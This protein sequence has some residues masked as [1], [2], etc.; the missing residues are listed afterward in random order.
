M[1]D[2]H[3]AVG[4]ARDNTGMSDLNPSPPS[5]LSPPS[6]PS[7]PSPLSPSRKAALDASATLILLVCCTLWG[8]N[9]IA[10][11]VSLVDVPPLM[12]AA[13]RSTGAVVLVLA[14]AWWRRVQGDRSVGPDDFFASKADA[15]RIDRS[16]AN[17]DEAR[18]RLGGRRF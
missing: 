13:W 3:G 8:L 11:K 12:Q 17:V 9:Q 1:R 18:A 14:W 6:P 16:R 2:G 7:P 15:V 5:P 10:A 4:K